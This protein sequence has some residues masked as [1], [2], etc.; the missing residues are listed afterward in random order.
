MAQWLSLGQAEVEADVRVNGG[1]R[2]V[3][4]GEGVRIDH[5][6]GS[7]AIDPPRRLSFTWR[8]PYTGGVATLVT[9]TLEPGDGTTRLVLVHERLPDEA[10]E[11]HRHGWGAL[12]DRLAAT[13]HPGPP[14]APRGTKRPHLPVGTTEPWRSTS[15]ARSR[16]IGP[17]LRW[18]PTPRI[19][20]PHPPGTRT[21]KRWNGGRRSRSG[22]AREWTSWRASSVD[23]WRIRMRSGNSSQTNGW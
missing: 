14:E 15:G 6:G 10:A 1:F 21:S 23:G 17:A 7:V 2:L 22:S 20:K 5:Q 9:V 3:M 11:S 19:R 18:R 16:S 4:V 12:L 8:S 13:L